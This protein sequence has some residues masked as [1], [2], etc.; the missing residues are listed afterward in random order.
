MW[1]LRVR[2]LRRF[3]GQSGPEG[4]LSPSAQL[5]PVRL[6]PGGR[7]PGD[8]GTTTRMEEEASDAH[9]QDTA[10]ASQNTGGH[11]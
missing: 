3:S 1:T 8:G 6:P 11:D 2:G 9:S 4:G 5:Q 7:H 10:S